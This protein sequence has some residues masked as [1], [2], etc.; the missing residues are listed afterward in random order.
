MGRKSMMEVLRTAR[1]AWWR[2]WSPSSR[3]DDTMRT[4]TKWM[5]AGLAA[6]SASQAM[7]QACDPFG[8][9][10]EAGYATTAA[11]DAFTAAALTEQTAALILALQG[12]AAQLSSNLQ[13]AL[14]G[15]GMIAEAKSNQ[16]TQRLV[17]SDH[18]AAA[19]AFQFSTTLCQAATGAALG[20]AQAAAA[21][22]D[23]VMQ[24]QANAR[25]S[26]GYQHPGDSVPPS[27]AAQKLLQDR[28]TEFCDAADPACQQKTAGTR[29]DGDRMPGAV[30]VVSR[31][32]D[33]IDKDQAAYLVQNL[34]QPVPS[35]AMTPRQIAAPDG[36]DAYVRSQSYRTQLNLAKD[37]TTTIL[38]DRRLPKI[39]PKYYNDLAARSG[40]PAA[41]GNVS[42]VD[43]D[44]MRYR[45]RFNGDY[46]STYLP[47]LGDS[48][49]LLREVAALKADELQQGLRTN[50]QLED[51]NLLLSSM[52]SALLE[53]K[54][55]ATAGT[56]K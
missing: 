20:V 30:L 43:L 6:V 36:R 44:N 47:G 15:Q 29:P 56:R 25:R 1:V 31:L 14:T 21:V 33:Q 45:D 26:S 28:Q 46:Y 35:P 22:P 39:D 52:L 24:A 5:V 48:A 4:N 19:K 34:T 3:G 2:K 50:E 18:M 42:A 49:P 27:Q 11:V 9:A 10:R 40:L 7:A 53:G 12:H 13:S 32:Q 8:A 17:Q 51:S 54:I 38:Y 37:V 55:V 23:R 16:D 41:T